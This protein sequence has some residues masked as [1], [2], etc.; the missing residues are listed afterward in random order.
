VRF[1]DTHGHAE[2]MT[3]LRPYTLQAPRAGTVTIKLKEDQSIPPDSLV[4]RIKLDQPD[5]PD[6]AEA[7]DVRSPLPGQISVIKVGKDAKVKVGEDLI[8]L[9]PDKNQVW[10]ALRALYLIGLPDDLPEVERYVRG[11]EG[12]PESIKQ[13]ATLTAEAIRKRQ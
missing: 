11:V 7:I 1:A 9:S 8:V 3:M 5:G 10:E 4:A 2:L 6:G 12:M 13:Q